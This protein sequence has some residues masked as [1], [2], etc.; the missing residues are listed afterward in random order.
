[1]RGDDPGGEWFVPKNT[2]LMLNLDSAVQVYLPPDPNDGTRFAVIDVAGALSATNLTVNGNGRNIEGVSTLVL[3]ED[4]MAREWFY[5]ADT[6]NWVRTTPLIE[7]DTAPFPEEFDDFFITMLAIRLNPAYG[8]AL[9]GQSQQALQRARTQMR[10]RYRQEIPT[11][12]Q[13][14][15]QRMPRVNALRGDD[16]WGGYLWNQP[17]LGDFGG[18]F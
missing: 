3:N 5:R 2:R 16:H 10:A 9:D 6:G 1:M 18:R 11:E 8:V 14:A 4:G 13:M 7:G 17:N 15:L 12:G